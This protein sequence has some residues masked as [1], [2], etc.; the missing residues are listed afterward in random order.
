MRCHNDAVTH[1]GNLSV[2]AG[3]QPYDAVLL[4]S[5][6]GPEQPEDVLPFLRNVTAGRGIPDDRLAEVAEHY[7]HFGGQS[8]I[9]AQNRRLQAALSAEFA[10]Q[11]YDL[12]VLWGNRNWA[13]YVTDVVRQAHQDGARKFL[14]IPTSA[15]SSYSGCRQYREDLGATA[16]ALAAEGRSLE[17]AKIRPFA[18]HP[19]FIA[20]NTQ[21]AIAA[22]SELPTGSQLMFVTHSIPVGMNESSGDPALAGAYEAQHLAVSQAIAAQ[23]SIELG[24]QIPWQLVYCS[25][26]GP[27][28]QPWLEPDIGD[29][30]RELP[31]AQIPGV[32]V[33]PIGFISDHM[34]VAFDLDTEARQIAHEIGLEF[35]RADTVGTDPVFVQALVELSLER[36]A[37]ARGESPVQAAAAG[38]GPIPSPCPAG[39]CPNPRG[40][41]PAACGQ[42]WQELDLPTLGELAQAVARELGELI[43]DQRPPVVEVA[44]TKSSA[45]DVVTEMDQRAEKLARQRLLAARPG[46][47]F[48]GEE[49]AAVVG[50]SGITWVVD[51][52]DGTVNYLYDLPGY[53]V[54]I[55]AVT[56]DP[57][58]PGGYQVVAGAVFHPASGECYSA[59]VGSGAWCNGRRLQVTSVLDPAQALVATGFGYEAQ[60]RAEQARVL[61]LVLPKIRD[62]RRIGSAALDLCQVAAGRVDAYY[63]QG[64]KPW[65]LV[66]G[67]LIASEAGALVSGLAGAP[68]GPSLVLAAQP[69]LHQQLDELLQVCLRNADAV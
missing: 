69:K 23:A 57:K 52:I 51:P 33:C 47:G 3:L 16:V 31:K 1:I 9:N 25:R 56:G 49:G 35:V 64:L 48:L 46:D 54:S 45:T 24:R 65:D 67:Q 62:I 15:Y 19:G 50:T 6:G 37:V 58:V 32:A 42:D 27:P 28:G 30:L 7:H 20:V 21:V 2:A 11:G 22:L 60:W 29:A 34:E 5:F 53:C 66:A 10:R 26:S 17:F 36:A 61:A 59:V 63:E 41:R 8:P 14:V 44:Q 4:L 55:A 43:R 13:P 12:P 39:C 40:S 18:N 38:L 68:A